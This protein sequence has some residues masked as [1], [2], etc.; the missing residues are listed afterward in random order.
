MFVVFKQVHLCCNS[1]RGFKPKKKRNQT[2]PECL[3]I[4]QWKCKCNKTIREIVNARESTNIFP[5]TFLHKFHGY[6]R[7]H[8]YNNFGFV[9]CYILRECPFQAHFFFNKVS[10]QYISDLKFYSAISVFPYARNQL[11][12][13]KAKLQHPTWLPASCCRSQINSLLFV[14]DLM[15]TFCSHLILF[16]ILFFFFCDKLCLRPPFSTC[17]PF[18]YCWG[19]T[20]E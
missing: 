19:F 12:I 13:W 18:I 2:L 8:M 7:L 14:Y 4:F 6:F 16:P 11:N 20:N 1:E 3:P 9:F 10:N 5:R 15:A 17:S